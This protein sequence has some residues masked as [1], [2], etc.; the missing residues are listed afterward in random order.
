[1]AIISEKIEKEKIL[2]EIES[3]NLKSAS[4]NTKTKIL[5]ITF[6]NGSIYQYDDVE[7]NIFTKLRYASSQGKY[8]NKN[9]N[10]KYKYKKIS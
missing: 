5:Q 3:S 1:M 6:K 4:Y 9:I 10:G 8:F 2:I 7:W